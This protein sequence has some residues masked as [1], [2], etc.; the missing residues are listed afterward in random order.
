MCLLSLVILLWPITSE[1]QPTFLAELAETVL[2]TSENRG[3]GIIYWYP[4]AIKVERMNIWNGDAAA[5]FDEDGDVLPGA[6]AM[7]PA[8]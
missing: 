6:K 7:V 5:V 8:K 1:G 3:L 2:Q 4:E